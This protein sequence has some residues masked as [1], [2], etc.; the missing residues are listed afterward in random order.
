M[1]LQ[2]PIIPGDAVGALVN[3]ELLSTHK[4]GSIE[5]VYWHNSESGRVQ[6]SAHPLSKRDEMVPHRGSLKDVPERKLLPN[7]AGV[8]FHLESLVQLKI[9]GDAYARGFI[10]GLTMR[11][12]PSATNLR[13]ESQNVVIEGEKTTISTI[14]KSSGD[15]RYRCQ[16]DLWFYQNEN[17]FRVATTFFNDGETPLDLEML[18]SFNLGGI[19]PFMSYDEPGRLV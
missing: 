16:H 15:K 4:V 8:A 2:T 6:L 5:L 11:E 9:R 1:N 3:L 14:L 7:P 10:A 19:S 17:G 13:F 18:T 12:S